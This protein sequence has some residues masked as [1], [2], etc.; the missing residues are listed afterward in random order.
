M[1]ALVDWMVDYG[2]REARVLF[3]KAVSEGL[4][5]IPNCPEPLYLFIKSLERRPA[6]VDAELIDEGARFIHSTGMTARA[7]PFCA[8]FPQHLACA[9][10][11]FTGAP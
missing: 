9:P 5:T 11:A 1:D 8:G 3:D 6:W 2:P 4:A 7:T 10:G